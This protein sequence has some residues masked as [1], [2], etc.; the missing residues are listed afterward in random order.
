MELKEELPRT[1]GKDPG[2][3]KPWA[4]DEQ[5]GKDSREG[6]VPNEG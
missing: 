5:A 3:G 2:G 6:R 1:Q 4:V